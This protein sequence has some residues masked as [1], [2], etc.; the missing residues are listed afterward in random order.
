[1]DT[2]EQQLE[3]T[4][5]AP[6]TVEDLLEWIQDLLVID[7]NGQPVHIPYSEYTSEATLV[8][9][10]IDGK[11]YPC[12]VTKEGHVPINLFGPVVTKVLDWNTQTAQPYPGSQIK[13]LE[14]GYIVDLRMLNLTRLNNPF[15]ALDDQ[16]DKKIRRSTSVVDFRTVEK[17]L[18]R[19]AQEALQGP[20]PNNLYVISWKEP[21]DAHSELA[22]DEYQINFISSETLTSYSKPQHKVYPQTADYLKSYFTDVGVQVGTINPLSVYDKEAI[23][24][25]MAD[26]TKLDSFIFPICYVINLNSFNDD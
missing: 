25:L 11:E 4:Q 21:F 5:N 1:M 9:G 26:T 14:P 23:E 2:K 18:P 22:L 16:L 19:E 12:F 15:A 7:A 6:A 24:E 8:G 10:H 3:T 13:K 20:V 17:Q